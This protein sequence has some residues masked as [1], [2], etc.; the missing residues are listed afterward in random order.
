MFV[1]SGAINDH[2]SYWVVDNIIQIQ[3]LSVD[4]CTKLSTCTKQ[5]I[6]QYPQPQAHA[7]GVNLTFL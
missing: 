7:Q 1:L 4:V 3:S 6:N 5:V 2:L